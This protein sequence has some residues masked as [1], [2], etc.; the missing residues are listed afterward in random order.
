MAKNVRQVS[1]NSELVPFNAVAEDLAT[2]G[3]TLARWMLDPK[4]KLP[5]P[6]VIASRR[7]FR[8]AEIEAWKLIFFQKA[9]STEQAARAWAAIPA[10]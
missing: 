7:Y 6:I 4:M 9:R 1:P 10:E 5:T 2:S 8:R 3:K